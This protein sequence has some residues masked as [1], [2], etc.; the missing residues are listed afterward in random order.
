MIPNTAPVDIVAAIPLAW[1]LIVR[2][3]RFRA[4]AWLDRLP[5]RPAWRIGYGSSTVDYRPV[6][7]GMSCTRKDAARWS[8]YDLL[9]A[10]NQVEH[11]VTVA[12]SAQQCAALIAL[13]HDIGLGN[14]ED[15]FVLRAL[16]A[17]DHAAAAEHFLDHAMIDGVVVP[18][19]R[20]RRDEERALFLSR[21]LSAPA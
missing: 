11:F 15:S 20:A 18:E 4:D 9:L 17:G 12:L 6:T 3:G 14:F 5:K 19:L 2:P 1:P 7:P 13:D 10:S 21:L 16:N 8:G